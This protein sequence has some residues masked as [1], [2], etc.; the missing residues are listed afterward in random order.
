MKGQKE[1][2]HLDIEEVLDIHGP[3]IYVRMIGMFQVTS[4]R[5]EMVPIVTPCITPSIA[6]DELSE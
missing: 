4:R 3:I 5:E 1:L 2:A 6:I